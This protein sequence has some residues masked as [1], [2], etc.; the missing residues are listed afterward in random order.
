[1]NTMFST[2]YSP[3]AITAGLFQPQISTSHVS[4]TRNERVYLLSALQAENQNAA[5]LE[6]GISKVQSEL[7]SSELSKVQR[8]RLKRHRAQLKST[9][10]QTENQQRALLDNL[11]R[12]DGMIQRDEQRA[13]GIGFIGGLGGPSWLGADQQTLPEIRPI[14]LSG[15]YPV[16]NQFYPQSSDSYRPHPRNH[17]QLLSSYSPTFQH[18]NIHQ[19]WFAPPSPMFPSEYQ[20]SLLYAQHEPQ[21][22]VTYFVPSS[23]DE[24]LGINNISETTT[25]AT[26]ESSSPPNL[27]TEHSK[28]SQMVPPT[29]AAIVPALVPPLPTSSASPGPGIPRIYST[30][31]LPDLIS[32]HKIE[33]PRPRR[34]HPSR[35]KHHQPSD[36]E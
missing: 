31:S 16:D 2:D 23:T 24:T 9:L 5:N 8:K 13:G 32:D 20:A 22:P 10:R 14:P 11:K 4:S 21:F 17:L 27:A 19:A 18:T 1:M 35:F 36:P 25:I 12:V 34:M 3:G 28:S 33:R 29:L 6:S 30:Q 26:F 15:F 7:Q